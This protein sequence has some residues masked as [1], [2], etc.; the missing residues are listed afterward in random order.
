[1]KVIFLD[2]DGILN[3]S[4]TGDRVYKIKKETGMQPIEIYDYTTKNNYLKLEEQI[5]IWLNKHED[6]ESFI[7]IDDESSD[8]IR[9]IGKELIK[10]SRL[11]DG[12]MIMN[13]DDCLGLCKEHVGIAVNMLNAKNKVLKK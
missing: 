6:I 10:T 2:I 1:M 13:M 8:L 11:P 4:K 3:T 9:F 12:E 7:V 5:T